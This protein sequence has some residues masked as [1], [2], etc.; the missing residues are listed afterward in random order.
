MSGNCN[1]WKPSKSSLIAQHPDEL[2]DSSQLNHVEF[3][4]IYNDNFNEKSKVYFRY[5]AS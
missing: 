4:L 5:R 3:R 2:K 1:G